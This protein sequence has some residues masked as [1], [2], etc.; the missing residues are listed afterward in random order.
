ML[1]QQPA[2]SVLKDVTPADPGYAHLAC[3]FR[4]RAQ[5][6]E[7]GVAPL[8][9]TGFPFASRPR[10]SRCAEARDEGAEFLF[11]PVAVV[12]FAFERNHAHLLSAPN[13]SRCISGS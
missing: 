3:L 11:A 9:H 13:S 10:R 2:R 7:L 6:I 5:Q 1:E 8:R 4:Q 12:L